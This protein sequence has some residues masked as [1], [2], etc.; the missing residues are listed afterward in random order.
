[1]DN[2]RFVCADVNCFLAIHFKNSTIKYFNSECE[3][4]SLLNDN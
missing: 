1:M 2:V 4:C 3:F